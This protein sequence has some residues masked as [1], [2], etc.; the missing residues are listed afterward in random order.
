MKRPIMRMSIATVLLTIVVIGCGKLPIKQYYVINYLPSSTRERQH[1]TPYP[2]TIRLR[3]FSIEEAYNRPQIVYR[4]SPFELGYYVYRVWAVKPTRM[5]TDL[6]YKHLQSAK[7]VSNVIR[8]YDEGHPDYEL[9]GMIEALEEYDSEELWFAH[10]AIRVNLVRL[11]DGMQV[12]TRRFDL[13]KR[14]YQHQPEYVI[15]EMS[16]ITETILTQVIYDL[17]AKLAEEHG[18]VIDTGTNS[19][20]DIQEV[21]MAPSITD[22]TAS[23]ETE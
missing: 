11:S 2:F 13:R 16:V 12:Y 6:V 17:D 7:L 23:K 19:M 10:L 20:D 22:T 1:D 3:D 21:D 5:I 9:S 15:R 4:Q 18:L 8:R 14:V